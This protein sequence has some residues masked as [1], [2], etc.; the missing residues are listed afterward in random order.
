MLEQTPDILTFQECQELLKVGK[1]TLLDLLHNNHY[2]FS[3]CPAADRLKQ[4]W[5][6][7]EYDYSRSIPIFVDHCLDVTKNPADKLYLQELYQCYCDF[8]NTYD[9]PVTTY[10]S[11]SAWLT[12]NIEGCSKKRIHETDKNPMAGLVGLRLK[13]IPENKQLL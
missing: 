7:R 3:P 6:Y 5:R 11:F 12:T 2:T 1:N 8:C 4:N 10:N 13:N 9:L